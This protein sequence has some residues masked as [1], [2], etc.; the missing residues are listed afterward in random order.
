MPYWNQGET[1]LELYDASG[2]ILVC[3]RKFT[4]IFMSV[5]QQFY[6]IDDNP[7]NLQQGI[8]NMIHFIRERC[9]QTVRQ[10]AV[11]AFN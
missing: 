8:I 1:G 7:V 11:Q 5:L 4:E 2:S 6:V 9:P 3:L 10:S